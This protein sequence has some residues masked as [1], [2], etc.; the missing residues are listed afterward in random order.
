MIKT[1]LKDMDGI[2]K[3]EFDNVEKTFS[4]KNRNVWVNEEN[5]QVIIFNDLTQVIEK[6][7]VKAAH[8]YQ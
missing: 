7:Q 6:E 4:V 8:K 5:S 3:M 1:R 2:I